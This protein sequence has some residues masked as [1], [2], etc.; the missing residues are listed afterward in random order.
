MWLLTAVGVPAKSARHSSW[1]S[2]SQC[3]NSVC[4]L[5]TYKS[6]ETFFFHGC[7]LHF[8][9]HILPASAILPVASCGGCLAGT[10][11]RCPDCHQGVSH[12]LVME[13]ATAQDT[14][15]NMERIP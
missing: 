3:S 11:I 2:A 1:E 14:A 8:G 12:K 10:Y 9:E 15:L 13:D 6:A 5:H 7:S 4:W